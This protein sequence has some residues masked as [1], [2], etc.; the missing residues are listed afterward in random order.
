MLRRRKCSSISESISALLWVRRTFE[1]PRRELGLCVGTFYDKTV[2]REGNDIN[3]YLPPLRNCDKKLSSLRFASIAS[4]TSLNRCG[5]SFQCA[6]LR[7]FKLRQFFQA[8][9]FNYSDLFSPCMS[10]IKQESSS[11]IK[12]IQSPTLFFPTTFV[13]LWGKSAIFDP[14][15]CSIHHLE[16]G[17]LFLPD[18]MRWGLE[19]GQKKRTRQ[20]ISQSLRKQ[21]TFRKVTKLIAIIAISKRSFLFYG[22]EYFPKSYVET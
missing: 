17:K 22:L 18:V 8:S 20:N 2:R 16:I 21:K 5:E 10:T 9:T 7:H 4:K 11:H 14:N 15:F 12:W 6:V 13:F 1:C 19:G 3:H